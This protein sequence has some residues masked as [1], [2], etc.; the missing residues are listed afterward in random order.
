VEGFADVEV[1]AGTILVLHC[2]D[3]AVFFALGSMVMTDFLF[4]VAR[5][6][7]FVNG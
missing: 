4:K 3:N 5:N 1:V 6:L 2:L 7:Y